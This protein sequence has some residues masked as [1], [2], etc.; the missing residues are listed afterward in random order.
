MCISSFQESFIMLRNSKELEGF[1]IH[2]TDGSIGSIKEIYFDDRQWVVRYLVV[3]TGAWLMSKKVLLS[4][5]GIS[6]VNWDKKELSVA[7][8]KAQVK[9]SPDIDT[10]KPVSQQHEMDYLGYYGYP[11][12]WGDSGYWGGYPSPYM[13]APE[14]RINDHSTI[15]ADAN[16]PYV[17]PHKSSRN[18][19]L[20]SDTEVMNYHIE[21]TDGELGHLQGM[22]ID[23]DTWAIRYLIINT[24]NWWLGHLILV[25]PAWIKEVSWSESKV[26]VDMTQAQIKNAPHYDAS[27]ALERDKEKTLHMHYGRHGYWE[28]TYLRAS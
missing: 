28:N 16:V 21:A 18:H 3:E 17:A 10:H 26:Y 2:A 11:L 13:M 9:G 19:H 15:V 6:H 25:A 8:S 22:L 7:I 20:R 23:P 1:A 27:V 5:V 14:Y 24:S 4:P 12:Y